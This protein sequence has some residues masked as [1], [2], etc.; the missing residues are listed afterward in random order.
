MDE[1]E[2]PG[3]DGQHAPQEAPSDTNGDTNGGMAGDAAAAAPER[4]GVPEVDAVLDEVEGL[5]GTPVDEHV[6]VF[7]RAHEQLR[8]ALDARPDA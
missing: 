8:R 2:V 6:A 7:E 3:A 5:D 1:Q 4:T